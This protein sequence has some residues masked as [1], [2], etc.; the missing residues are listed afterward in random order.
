MLFVSVQFKIR[1]KL[2]LAN[3]VLRDQLQLLFCQISQLNL[4]LT[5]PVMLR[6]KVQLRAPNGVEV[7]RD[8]CLHI[9]AVVC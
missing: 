3:I 1:L 4:R 8:V 6:I 7:P 5:I 9:Y 2:Q